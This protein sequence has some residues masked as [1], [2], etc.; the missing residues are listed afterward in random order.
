MFGVLSVVNSLNSFN[1]LNSL[2]KILCKYGNFDA[3][4]SR[5]GASMLLNII[6]RTCRRLTMSLSLVDV[7]GADIAWGGGAFAGFGAQ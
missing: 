5:H 6:I 4:R 7:P 2:N 1:N 3:G